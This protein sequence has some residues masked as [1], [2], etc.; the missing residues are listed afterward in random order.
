M[1]TKMEVRIRRQVRAIGRNGN[2]SG[3]DRNDWWRDRY[4][5][6]NGYIRRAVEERGSSGPSC[7]MHTDE[8]SRGVAVTVP[9]KK[10]GSGGTAKRNA[11]KWSQKR[12]SSRG[13]R[14]RAR[15]KE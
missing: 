8:Y 13:G 6:G 4:R 12:W 14:D 1:P 10:G 3:D 7:T 2:G 15:D 11:K 9:K 5:C